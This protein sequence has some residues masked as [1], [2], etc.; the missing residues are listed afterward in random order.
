MQ[1]RKK[2]KLDDDGSEKRNSQDGTRWTIGTWY[3]SNIMFAPKQTSAIDRIAAPVV[4]K[5]PVVLPGPTAPSLLP[6]KK[7]PIGA[8]GL[9]E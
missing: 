7:R 1:T 9:L 3:A 5:N 4:Q 8:S 6:V 2:Q